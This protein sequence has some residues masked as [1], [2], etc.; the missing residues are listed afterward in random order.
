MIYPYLVLSCL[1]NYYNFIYHRTGFP[2]S[3]LKE[4]LSNRKLSLIFGAICGSIFAPV[5]FLP[6][7]F[8]L[9]FLCAQILAANSRKNAVIYGYLFGLGLYLSTIY[10]IAFG[11]S[12]YIEQFWWAIPF[13]LFGLPAFMALFYG[14]LAAFVW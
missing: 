9:S 7:I 6:G 1:Y 13:A 5:F 3:G 12:V 4:M 8:A 2:A 14:A 11:V 10:W